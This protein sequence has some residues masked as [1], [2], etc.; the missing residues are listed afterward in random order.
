MI[1]KIRI[2]IVDD[3]PTVRTDL[4]TLLELVEG[5]EVVGEASNGSDALLLAVKTHPDV[6]LIDL[7]RKS[8]SP[9]DDFSC[10]QLLKTQVPTVKVFALSAAGW[11]QHLLNRLP[12]GIDRLFRK[13]TETGLLLDWINRFEERKKDGCDDE[14]A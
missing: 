14:R 12:N 11:R 13:G 10:I 9:W 7:D 5:V 3:Y 1:V 8:P 6:V 2:L 4:H